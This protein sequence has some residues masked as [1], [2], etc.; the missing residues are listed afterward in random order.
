MDFRHSLS[1]D[2]NIIPIFIK[3]TKLTQDPKLNNLEYFLYIDN[4]YLEN[5]QYRSIYYFQLYTDIF[6]KK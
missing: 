5:G 2:I 6:K 4:Y 1:Y 3:M